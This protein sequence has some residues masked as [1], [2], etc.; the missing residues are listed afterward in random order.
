MTTI[1]LKRQ[2]SLKRDCL[3][4]TLRPYGALTGSALG[5][6]ARNG[7]RGTRSQLPGIALPR[8]PARLRHGG[9]IHDPIPEPDSPLECYWHQDGASDAPI[10]RLRLT[11]RLRW[12]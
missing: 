7:L 6:F 11:L 8:T 12:L 5:R 2:G 9:R 4:D 10:L 1:D 3:C